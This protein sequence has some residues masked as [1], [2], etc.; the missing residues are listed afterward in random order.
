MADLDFAKKPRR[1]KKNCLSSD[2]FLRWDAF[3]SPVLFNYEE[4]NQTYRSPAGS[5]VSLLSMTITLVFII[6]Q[7]LVLLE[8]RGSTF[9]NSVINNYLEESYTYTGE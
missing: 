6:Q 3:G 4:G 7:A 8:Y 2:S 9:T 5:C 1:S